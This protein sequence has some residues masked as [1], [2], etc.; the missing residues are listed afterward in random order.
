M[1]GAANLPSCLDIVRDTTIDFLQHRRMKPWP[2]VGIPELPIASKSLS[3]T[4]PGIG[5][6]IWKWELTNTE[7]EE[8]SDDIDDT[9]ELWGDPEMRIYWLVE[10]G[11]GVIRE[12][13]DIVEEAE[14]IRM[15]DLKYRGLDEWP[16]DR[17][18]DESS[19]SSFD[20]SQSYTREELRNKIDKKYARFS[21]MREVRPSMQKLTNR[22]KEKREAYEAEK[23]RREKKRSNGQSKGSGAPKVDGVLVDPED[24]SE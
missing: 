8:D 10:S 3:E 22:F 16:S 6:P 4:S 2:M 1:F 24:S 9:N 17:S 19:G 23:A 5:S 7:D 11:E 15:A 13:D 21:T 14:R 20:S 12:V 18:G